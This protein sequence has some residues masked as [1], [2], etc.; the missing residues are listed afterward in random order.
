[1]SHDTAWKWVKPEVV[2]ALHDAM[3][4]IYGGAEG[5]LNLGA[6]EA[7]I[8]R[9]QHLWNYADPD[10][11]ALAAAYGYGL[12]RSHGFA[13][14]NKRIAWMATRLFLADNGFSLQYQDK[15]AVFM[16]FDVAGGSIT[17]LDF[18]EWI[19]TRITDMARSR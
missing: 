1:M 11:A 9:P 19:R 14:G 12:A 5:V 4:A 13:D 18:G 8:A 2:I 16:M 17:E 15:A 10:A 3:I 7:A 6:I